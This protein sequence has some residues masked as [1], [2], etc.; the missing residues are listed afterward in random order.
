MACRVAWCGNIEYR[1]V[2]VVDTINN[3][4]V[5]YLRHEK[6]AVE[7]NTWDFKE[8]NSKI[9]RL[10]VTLLTSNLCEFMCL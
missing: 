6:E 2:E 3:R 5:I 4:A 9:K 10:V 1:I 8:V 7:V